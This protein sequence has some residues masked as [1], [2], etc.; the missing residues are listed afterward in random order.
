MAQLQRVMIA[1]N[2]YAAQTIALTP[3]QQHY[4]ARVLRLRDGDRFIAICGQNSWQLAELAN[5]QTQAQCLEVIAIQTELAQPLTLCAALP[6][7][8]GFDEVVRAVTELGVTTLIPMLSTRTV[9]NPSAQKVERW[10]R[11]AAE[12]AEQS[13]RQMVPEIYEP[14]PFEQ[15]LSL[16]QSDRFAPQQTFIGVTDETAPNLLDTL[17]TLPQMGILMM[18]GPEGGWTS[19]EQA[20]A[21]DQGFQPVSL[22]RR[23]LRAI[24]ASIAVVSVLATRIDARQ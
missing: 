4:L 10:R 24:T 2:Q 16:A 19:T 7:G 18:I 14:I 9:V 20:M 1:P 15:V 22:G 12:A 23:I 3:E 11:I 17:I 5:A 21:I 6:K 13:C 8:Q